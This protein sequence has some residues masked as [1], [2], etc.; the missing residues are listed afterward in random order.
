MSSSLPCDSCCSWSDSSN[1]SSG[2]T[3]HPSSSHPSLTLLPEPT[4]GVQLWSLSAL[5][6]NSSLLPL[7]TPQS[8]WLLLQKCLSH[9]TRMSLCHEHPL[10]SGPFLRTWVTPCTPVGTVHVC[11]DC[12]SLSLSFSLSP[13]CHATAG[14]SQLAQET[15]SLNSNTPPASPSKK[16]AHPRQQ[17]SPSL[18]S[19]STCD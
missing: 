6:S 17:H 18:H 1:Q 3:P 14:N 15:H 19:L 4:P 9:A 8:L 16:P 7:H 12:C 13:C 2:I 11:A 5:F 10:S